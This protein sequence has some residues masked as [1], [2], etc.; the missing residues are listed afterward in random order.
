M[1]DLIKRIEQLR[2]SKVILYATSDRPAPFGGQIGLDVIPLF[3]KHLEKIGKVAKIDLVIFSTGGDTLVPWRLVAMIREYCGEYSLIVLH[4][5]HSAA[6]MIALGAD[7][8]LM[9]ELSEMSPIDPSVTNSYNPSDPQNSQV[10]L[11]ISV[12]DVFAYLDLAS[13]KIGI[14]REEELVKVFN[15]LIESNPS[16]HPLAIGNVFRSHNLIR[17]LA[18]KLLAS[19]AK[20]MSDDEIAKV[21]S[22]LTE[23]LHS[24]HYFIGRKEA[25]DDIGIKTVNQPNEQEATW[26]RDAYEKLTQDMKLGITFNP[27][28][29]LGAENR[30]V[31]ESPNAI[32]QSE[33]LKSEFLTQAEITRVQI[34]I[35]QN[36]A[37][38]QIQVLQDQ[39]NLRIIGQSWK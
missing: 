28:N 30:K 9:D 19:H 18:N 13:K 12:E 36:T 38:G 26:M 39:I 32:L 5:A 34:P 4:K 7:S 23:K 6:T 16:V 27:E 11:P 15:K 14:K 8:V 21:I 25:K 35:I 17:L 20:K 2:G 24:H 10:K 3:K 29:E 22:I 33:S 31:V 37:N 1:E